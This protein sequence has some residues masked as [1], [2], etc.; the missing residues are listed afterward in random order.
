MGKLIEKK[1]NEIVSSVLT[2]YENGRVIDPAEMFLFQEGWYC[3][4]FCER[5]QDIRHFELKRMLLY[6][7]MQVI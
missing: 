3:A 5:K 4:A 7:I 6:A 1:I 2:D